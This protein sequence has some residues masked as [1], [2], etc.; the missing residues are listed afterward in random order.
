VLGE[1]RQPDGFI[2]QVGTH[3]RHTRLD[4]CGGIGVDLVAQV[5]APVDQC[6]KPAAGQIDEDGDALGSQRNANVYMFRH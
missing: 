3:R 1:E 5:R 6:G 2:N 4:E